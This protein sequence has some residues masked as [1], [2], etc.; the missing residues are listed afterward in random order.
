MLAGIGG[1]ALAAALPAYGGPGPDSQAA[2]RGTVG[3]SFLYA[4]SL[5]KVGAS[6]QIYSW[7]KG[8]C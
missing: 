4:T 8:T 3:R 6:G 7:T 2:P 1:M 5:T